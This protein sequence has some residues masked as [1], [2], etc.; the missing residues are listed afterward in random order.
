MASVRNTNNI[1]QRYYAAFTLCRHKLASLQPP[2]P[3]SL[4]LSE[5]MCYHA[6]SATIHNRHLQVLPPRGN[7]ACFVC[8][9]EGHRADQ[10]TGAWL[11]RCLVCGVVAAVLLYGC[12]VHLPV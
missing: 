12:S 8:G 5:R 1:N 6:T 4:A 7:T 9:Q 2:K 10:C 11:A 3:T